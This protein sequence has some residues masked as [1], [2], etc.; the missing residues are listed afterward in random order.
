LGAAKQSISFDGDKNARILLENLKLYLGRLFDFR[1]ANVIGEH[2]QVFTAFI[3][4][5]LAP[6]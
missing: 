1:K 6:K 4:G 3:R 5:S 2:V